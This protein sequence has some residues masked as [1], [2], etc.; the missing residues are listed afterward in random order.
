MSDLKAKMHQNRFLLGLLPRPR[1]GSLQHSRPLAGFKGP[2][3]KGDRGKK[4]GKEREGE[5]E[6]RKGD[7]KVGEAPALRWY[8]ALEWLIR[9]C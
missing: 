9:P 5:E 1:W 2:T 6:G 7:G 8:G 4:G 3:S